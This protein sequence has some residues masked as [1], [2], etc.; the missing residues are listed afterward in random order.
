MGWK[1][2]NV[3]H[4]YLSETKEGPKL[5]DRQEKERGQRLKGGVRKKGRAPGVGTS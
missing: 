3:H 2:G 4:L 5:N 1:R